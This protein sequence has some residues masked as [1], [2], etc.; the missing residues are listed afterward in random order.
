MI[1]R[2]FL[3][4][5]GT[6]VAVGALYAW[7]YTAPAEGSGWI[8]FVAFLGSLGLLN[9]ISSVALGTISATIITAA[10]GAAWWLYR[11]MPNSVWVL[12]LCVLCGLRMFSMLRLG[13]SGKPLVDLSQSRTKVRGSK[14]TSSY[15]RIKF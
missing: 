5:I 14:R 6:A 7:T 13:V 9:S 2:A 1:K 15:I 11:P 12:G 4:L 10:S 8:L 3:T